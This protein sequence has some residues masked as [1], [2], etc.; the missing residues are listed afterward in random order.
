MKFFI[1]FCSLILLS[2]LAVATPNTVTQNTK[3]DVKEAQEQFLTLMK[4]S[5]E[6][7]DNLK[8][9]PPTLKKLKA[10]SEAELKQYEE[11]LNEMDR[12]YAELNSISKEYPSMPQRY[13][14]VGNEAPKRREQAKVILSVI[15]KIRDERVS[16]K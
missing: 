8:K 14:D 1:C 2:S 13:I 9:E 4:R 11:K 16:K 12:I 3:L 5:F 15:R 6:V 10:S 7:E